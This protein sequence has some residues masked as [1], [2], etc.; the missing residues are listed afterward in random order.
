MVCATVQEN[1]T[2]MR[3]VSMMGIGRT[4]SCMGKEAFITL[5]GNLLMKEAGEWMN[6]TDLA[7]YIIKINNK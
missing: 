2:I 4:I 3:V 7:K 6:F 1:F 5:M